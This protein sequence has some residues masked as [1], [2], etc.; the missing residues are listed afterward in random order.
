M[1]AEKQAQLDTRALERLKG[2]IDSLNDNE[3][4][5]PDDF[6]EKSNDEKKEIIRNLIQKCEAKLTPINENIGRAE[7]ALNMLHFYF[8]GLESGEWEVI[9]KEA[10]KL[11]NAASSARINF[12]K[13]WLDIYKKVNDDFEAASA[14][15]SAEQISKKLNLNLNQNGK[16]LTSLLSKIQIV[17]GLK[18]ESSTAEIQENL[19]NVLNELK[20]ILGKSEATSE[21]SATI[22]R[23]P[24]GPAIYHTR[25]LIALALATVLGGL[26]LTGKLEDFSNG[27]KELWNEFDNSDTEPAEVVEESKL[28]PTPTATHKP[29]E[30]P[31]PTPHP[32]TTPRPTPRATPTPIPTT[33]PTPTPTA[34]PAPTLNPVH[35]INSLFQNSAE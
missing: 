13:E 25:K 1:S 16:A 12:S 31:K 23:T 32:T 26:H 8:A 4:K 33:T 10:N 14:T 29:V 3:I 27:A 19:T 24:I 6:E 18:S 28:A 17:F 35:T 7:K 20:K 15:Y 21:P 34:T 5:F 11:N 30:T 22:D 9:R 2:T